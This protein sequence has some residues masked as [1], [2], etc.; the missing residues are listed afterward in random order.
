MK[1]LK[2][3]ITVVLCL[4]IG[5]HISAQDLPFAKDIDNFKTQDSISFPEPGNILFIGSSSFTMWKTIHEDLKGY[6]IINRGFGGSRLSDQ[7][8]YAEDIIYPYHP[9]QIVIYCGENDLVEPNA[10]AGIA[11]DRFKILF[12]LI[13][14]H[15]P[16]IPV[17]FVSIKPSPSRWAYRDAIVAANASIK[18]FLSEKENTSFID[19]YSLMLDESGKPIE[20]IFIKD[21]LHMN[22]DGYKIWIKAIT[23]HLLKL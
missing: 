21:R 7:L 15:F 11:L 18:L 17:A 5:L 2:H 19:V 3:I 22:P 4:F 23:P 9:R 6:P 12:N 13:R 20:S 1:T 16:D 14:K 10:T 8:L